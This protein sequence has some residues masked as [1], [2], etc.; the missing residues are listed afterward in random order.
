MTDTT[1]GWPGKPGVPRDPGQTQWH[2]LKGAAS[3]SKP[4][5][6]LW[7]VFFGSGRWA[8]ERLNDPVILAEME[9]IRPALP[10]GLTPD[11]ATALQARVAE[12][13]AIIREK[14]VEIETAY[15]HEG[16]CT[17]CHWAV[18]AWGSKEHRDDCWYVK[19]YTALEGKKE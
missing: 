18:R 4:R 7:G 15:P 10:Y 19:A 3:L 17:E 11:E 1:N 16:E 14:V 13:E 9:Y 2:W 8:D 12:L 6:Y 5:P